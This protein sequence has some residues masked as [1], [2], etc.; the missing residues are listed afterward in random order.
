MRLNFI[1]MTKK[2][3][4]QACRLIHKESLLTKD[5]YLA[6]LGSNWKFRFDY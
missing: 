6:K 4:G 3:S 2:F 1:I 5:D